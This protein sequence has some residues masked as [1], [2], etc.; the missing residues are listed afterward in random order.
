MASVDQ[1]GLGVDAMLDLSSTT[2]QFTQG[3]VQAELAE[4]QAQQRTGMD[5]DAWRAHLT[6]FFIQ[7]LASGKH[8]YLERLIR[9][10]EDFPD[11]D[12]Q[13]E[14]RLGMVLDGLAASLPGPSR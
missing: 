6:P 2:Q 7:L 8:P 3:F 12:V 4:T 5:I 1:L 13:F 14:R 11:P 10:A 9:D